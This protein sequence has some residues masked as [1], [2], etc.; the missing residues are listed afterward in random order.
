MAAQ[1]YEIVDAVADGDDVVLEVEWTGTLSVPLV[2]LPAGGQMR[3]RF[4][5]FLDFRDGKIARQRNYDC[6]DPW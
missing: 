1:T 2:T 4:A 5:V 3:A 6:F